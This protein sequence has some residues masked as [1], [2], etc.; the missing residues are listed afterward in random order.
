MRI[1]NRTKIGF[2]A[3]LFI[4]ASIT[5]SLSMQTAGAMA[6]NQ[7]WMRQYT[8]GS[9]STA[10]SN[11]RVATDHLGNVYVASDMQRISNN[12]SVSI[13]KYSSEGTQV[14]DASYANPT[15]PVAYTRISGVVLDSDNN[16]YVAIDSGSTLVTIKYNSSGSEQ[17][18][19]TRNGVRGTGGGA[20]VPK[21]IQVDPS[22]NV[23]VLDNTSIGFITIK[24]DS[25][26]N[27][28]W[29]YTDTTSQNGVVLSIGTDSNVYTASYDSGAPNTGIKVN[30]FDSN[31]GHLWTV[32]YS[33][34]GNNDVVTDMIVDSSQ[35]IHITG[36]DD[37]LAGQGSQ[38]YITVKFDS[39][40]VQQWAKKYS[41]LNANNG[42]NAVKVDS[43]GNVYVT[44]TSHNSG[45]T[46]IT[47]KYDSNG[48]QLWVSS[49]AYLSQDQGVTLALDS[50]N[51]IYI[52]GP[53]Y[54]NNTS[55]DFVVVKYDNNGNRIWNISLDSGG[56]DVLRDMALDSF[57]NV[58]ATGY[59]CNINWQDCRLATVK[60]NE[61][62]NTP[63]AVGLPAWTVNPLQQGQT[64]TL[65]AT[66]VDDS[67]GVS[68][69]QYSID[70]GMPQ[71]MIYDTSS[72]LWKVTFGSSL[73]ASTYNVTITAIDTAGNASSGVTDVLAVY[74]TANGY[75]TGHAKTLPT[76]DDILP[77]ARDTS[78][79]PA[80][81]VMGF[82][83]VTA[84]T[85]GSFDMSYVIKKNK[86]EF[87]LSSTG[88]SWMVVQDSTHASILGHGDLTTYVNG[89]KTVTQNVA[90]HFDITLGSNG[91][92][93]QVTVK[94]FDPGND[95]NLA[96]PAYVINDAVIPSGSNLM[97]HP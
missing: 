29:M 85:S 58:Y 11:S 61:I 40:G 4:G 59:N 52:A 26:G 65:S 57:G 23:Y 14:W 87:N 92:P 24:Y 10:G 38:S 97:I 56:V 16:L 54:S 30:K 17:W 62:D 12:Y 78:K 25:N 36:Y 28:L 67:S 43:V 60:Y 21:T 82:T 18:R 74:N 49:Y 15:N 96:S 5:N 71:S 51:N 46:A 22:G 33:I 55:Y 13:V 75:V 42:A 91:T 7:Q 89:V 20:S 88:I 48:N 35:N 9:G 76:V 70:G 84:P 2:L 94:M 53:G 19:A 37:T 44:G 69:V 93:D 79:N 27:Q 68:S 39:S 63:P 80:K 45:W 73:V 41:T 47:I 64:T 32:G 6:V 3:I 95:P 8:A 66:V 77:V 1:L 90:V 81:L 86:D 50:N 31:G 83:N 34:G 72:G